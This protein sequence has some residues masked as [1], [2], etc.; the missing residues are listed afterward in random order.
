MKTPEQI[1]EAVLRQEAIETLPKDQQLVKQFDLLDYTLEEIAIYMNITI[2]SA[3]VK[4][5]NANQAIKEY[6]QD[7][8]MGITTVPKIKIKKR[9]AKL[10]AEQ[11]LEIRQSTL[12]KTE[13]SKKYG[14]CLSAIW[15]VVRNKSHKYV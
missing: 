5:A 2:D 12:P 13:L 4:L 3:R 15:D 10:D 1:K 14:V 9:S 11:V 8:K 7:K 6:Y